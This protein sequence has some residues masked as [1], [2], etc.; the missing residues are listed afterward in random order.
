VVACRVVPGQHAGLVRER[1][2][3]GRRRCVDGAGAVLSP[4]S[5]SPWPLIGLLVA[6]GTVAAV[7]VGKAA[8]SIPSIQAELDAS[9]RQAGWL[10]STIN[11]VTALA[12][13]AIA[14]K[15]DRLGARRV[16]LL[17]TG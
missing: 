12:G 1:H 4:T 7:P 9:L 11:L 17:R 6:A 10:L 16:V 8:P 2:Q 3:H 14:V 13:M 5:R 15:G